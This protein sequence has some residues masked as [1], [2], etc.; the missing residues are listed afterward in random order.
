MYSNPLNAFYWIYSI[1]GMHSIPF[2]AFN[3]I[4]LYISVY[5]TYSSNSIQCIQFYTMYSTVQFWIFFNSEIWVALIPPE[6]QRCMC[7]THYQ[8]LN[9]KL[10]TSSNT[11][12]LPLQ[13]VCTHRGTSF[14]STLSNTTRIIHYAPTFEMN[15]EFQHFY[16]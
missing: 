12:F 6:N 7:T 5:L 16:M 11:V 2:N 9:T 10:C 15:T 1:Q 13:L 8:L 14:R 4:A 3:S